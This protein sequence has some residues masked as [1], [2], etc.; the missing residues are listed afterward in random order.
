[1]GR[2]V[3]LGRYVTDARTVEQQ[4]L[5]IDDSAFLGLLGGFLPRLALGRLG[6]LNGGRGRGEFLSCPLRG[7]RVW[8]VSQ[9]L[10]LP[11]LGRARG[12]FPVVLVLAAAYH[13]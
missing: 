8:P 7:D 10:G 13:S 1:M 9:G 11:G 6:R 4:I 3:H 2:S 5:L 12:P